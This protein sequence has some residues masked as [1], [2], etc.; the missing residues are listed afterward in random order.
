[1]ERLIVDAEGKVTIPLEVIQKRGLRPGDELAVLET[2]GG[3]FVYPRGI[4]ARTLAWWHGLTEEERQQAQAEAR[5][6][7][8][9]SEAER[10][11]IWSQDAQNDQPNL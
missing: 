9:L 1:M 4:D 6:Y 3:L 8:A 10:D 7:E 5:E 11:A 2:P